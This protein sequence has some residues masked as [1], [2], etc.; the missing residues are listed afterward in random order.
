MKP[1]YRKTEKWKEYIK[2]NKNKT[3]RPIFTKTQWIPKH[4]KSWIQPIMLYKDLNV[5]IY[6]PRQ[7][8]E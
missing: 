8:Q 1:A 6:S 4:P 2:D 3:L 7:L 5:F